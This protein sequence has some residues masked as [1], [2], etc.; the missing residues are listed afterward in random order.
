M[1]SDHIALVSHTDHTVSLVQLSNG[2]EAHSYSLGELAEGRGGV[3]SMTTLTASH[4]CSLGMSYPALFNRICGRSH[5]I[6]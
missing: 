6:T 5:I 4:P 2:F 1:G 3:L